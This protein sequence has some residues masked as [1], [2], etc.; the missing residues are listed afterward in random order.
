ML[1]RIPVEDVA[2]RKKAAIK[3]N[4]LCI[5]LIMGNFLALCL[6]LKNRYKPE[7]DINIVANARIQT[8]YTLLYR[9]IS[10]DVTRSKFQSNQISS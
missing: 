5:R 6:V 10:I 3:P 4:D 2:I 1:M 9:I 8:I 7:R